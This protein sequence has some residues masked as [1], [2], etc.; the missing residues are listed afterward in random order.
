MYT[1]T[2]ASFQE[3]CLQAGASHVEHAAYD[4]LLQHY[5]DATRHYHNLQHITASLGHLETIATQLHAPAAVALAIW[6]HDVIYDTHRKDNEEQSALFAQRALSPMHIPQDTIDG[7]VALIRSTAHNQDTPTLPDGWREDARWL[8]DIDLAILG[9]PAS[10]F[11]A[12]ETAI[13]NEFS[14]VEEETY[15]AGRSEV[16]QSFLAQDTLFQTEHFAEKWDTQARFNLHRLLQSLQ[17]PTP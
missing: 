7:I 1:S 15:R 8:H 3:A 10:I 4:E 16:I 14:W 17:A 13:R 11:A 2:F 5:N 12:Y 9:Q 6:Y